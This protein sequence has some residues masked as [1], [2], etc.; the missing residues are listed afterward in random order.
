MYFLLELSKPTLN[1]KCL[2][3]R[4]LSWAPEYNNLASTPMFSFNFFS[5]SNHVTCSL[6][7]V[8]IIV[9]LLILGSASSGFDA[10]SCVQHIIRN[11]GSEPFIGQR[12]MLLVSQRLCALSECLLLMDPFDDAFPNNHC[13]M[14]IM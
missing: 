4:Y 7:S 12:T 13:C 8:L 5:N 3:V 10:Q 6:I 9:L 14:F 1:F 11:L 2:L